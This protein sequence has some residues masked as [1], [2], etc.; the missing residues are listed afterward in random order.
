MRPNPLSLSKPGVPISIA[1]FSRLLD[2][3]YGVRVA[4]ACRINAAMPDAWGAEVDVWQKFGNP[5]GSRSNPGKKKVV[6]TQS[7]A[8]MSGLSARGSGVESRLPARSNR[9]GV[10][11]DEE[12]EF[13][14]GGDTP[15]CGVLKYAAAPPASAPTA[16]GWPKNVVLCVFNSF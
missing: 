7:G 10:A 4:L 5:S 3:L 13:K 14:T 2:N 9:I 1:V 11:P 8:T 12:K 15:N 6:L 16:F